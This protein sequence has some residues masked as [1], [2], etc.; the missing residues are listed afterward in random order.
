MN[1]YTYENWRARGPQRVRV[2]IGS[3]GFC[4]EGKGLTTGTRAGNG[5]W[6]GPSTV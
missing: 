6:Y 3:C 4:N 1:Y 2:H 5:K